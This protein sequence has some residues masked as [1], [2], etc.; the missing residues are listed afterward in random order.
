MD[1]KA[2]ASLVDKPGTKWRIAI[3]SK[4]YSS[5]KSAALRASVNA[6]KT[7][8]RW[9]GVSGVPQLFPKQQVQRQR[10]TP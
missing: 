5:V 10:L 1:V 2:N 9:T 8:G 7:V 4:T 6:G 3:V